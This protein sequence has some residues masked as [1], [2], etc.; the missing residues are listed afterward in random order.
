MDQD[1]EAFTIMSLLMHT[2][3]RILGTALLLLVLPAPALAESDESLVLSVVEAVYAGL[4][5]NEG[6]TRDWAAF[7]AL[8]LPDARLV[9]ARRTPDGVDLRITSPPEFVVKIGLSLTGRGFVEEIEHSVIKSYGPIAQVYTSW[10][11]RSKRGG[12]K[13]NTGA[14]MLN[15]VQ[16][17]EGW[18]VASWLWTREIENQ[19]LSGS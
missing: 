7:D 9:S 16:T 3:H 19:P 5:A 2:R 1:S 8:F 6:E 12:E 15:L 10:L 4:S 17:D 18:R 14:A 13:K 11:S